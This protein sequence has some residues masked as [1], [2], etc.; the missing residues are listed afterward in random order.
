MLTDR[1]ECKETTGVNILG[2][3]SAQWFDPA[4]DLDDSKWTLFTKCYCFLGLTLITLF[5]N[6]LLDTFENSKPLNSVA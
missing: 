5:R 2:S 4:P 6:V 3:A 1:V